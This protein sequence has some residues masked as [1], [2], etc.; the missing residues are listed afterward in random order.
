MTALF[1]KHRPETFKIG[2]VDELA[3]EFPVLMHL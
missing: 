1:T 2:T 3:N